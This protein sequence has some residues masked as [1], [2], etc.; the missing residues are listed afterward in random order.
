MELAGVGSEA[1]GI[2]VAVAVSVAVTVTVAVAVV[3]YW[4]LCYYAGILSVFS[5]VLVLRRC[6]AEKE[7][8]KCTP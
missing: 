4:F 1:V 5:S 7:K 8:E 6:Y 3:F 2:A